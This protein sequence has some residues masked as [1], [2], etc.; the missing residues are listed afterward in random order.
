MKGILQGPSIGPPSL[1]NIFMNDLSYFIETCSLTTYAN[2][3]TLDMISCT[4]E[5]VLSALRTDTE[6]LTGL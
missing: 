1:F 6:P 4:I 3:N 5:T 2:D